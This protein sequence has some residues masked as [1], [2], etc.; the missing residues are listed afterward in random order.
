MRLLTLVVL[1]F[2]GAATVSAGYAKYYQLLEIK[3]NAS[4][5]EIKKAYRRLSVK[6]H[7][8]KNKDAGA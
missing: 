1:F 6:Y 7:P 8:D 3:S 5:I 2:V 4:E